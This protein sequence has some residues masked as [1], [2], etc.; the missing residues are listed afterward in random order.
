MLK[1]KMISN[2]WDYNARVDDI[3]RGLERKMSTLGV[4]GFNMVN[5]RP[6]YVVN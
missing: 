4:A 5:I 3:R 1:I 2:N 6:H